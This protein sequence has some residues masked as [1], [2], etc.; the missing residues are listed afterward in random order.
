LRKAE[1]KVDRV[2]IEANAIFGGIEIRVPETWQVV[3]RGTGVFGGFGDQTMH[4]MGD[5]KHPEV[6][7]TGVAIFGGVNVKN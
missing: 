5:A 2:I 1:M 6:I 7:L 3:L 4:A